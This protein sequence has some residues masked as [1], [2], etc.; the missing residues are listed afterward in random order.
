MIERLFSSTLFSI[1]LKLTPRLI[2][3]LLPRDAAI[4]WFTTHA[5]R[6][7]YASWNV[8]LIYLLLLPTVFSLMIGFWVFLILRICGVYNIGTAWLCVWFVV[9][10]LSYSW[11]AVNQYASEVIAKHKRA[12][13]ETI[14]K[15]MIQDPKILLKRCSFYFFMN[16]I[17]A[18]LTTLKL[19]L[20]IFLFVLLHWPAWIIQIFPR[21]KL[22][23]TDSDTRTHY[24]VGYMLLS[25]IPGIVLIFFFD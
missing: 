19:V 12:K 24:Y 1:F 20:M 22:D 16:W 18:P 15:Y 8:A 14:T 7:I 13:A 2:Q 3:S 23:L 21:I 4:I 6:N 9:L 11:S 5:N 17:K 10:C 25:V